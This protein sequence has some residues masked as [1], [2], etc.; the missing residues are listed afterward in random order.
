M[1]NT[2]EQVCNKHL[3]SFQV[4]AIEYAKKHG[5]EALPLGNWLVLAYPDGETVECMTVDGVR[6]ACRPFALAG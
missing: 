4:W 6:A 2:V 1:E 5:L 3:N